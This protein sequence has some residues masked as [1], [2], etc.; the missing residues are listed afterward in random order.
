[1]EW[2]DA[3]PPFPDQAA[4]YDHIRKAPVRK[5]EVEKQNGN[6]DEAFKTAARV[7]EAEYEWPFQSHASMGPACAL[8][9]IKDGQVTCW[10]GSQKPHFTARRRGRRFS[11]C[12]PKGAWD[13][14]RG[15][16]LLRPQ[17][18]RR[19]GDGRRGARQGRRPAGARAIH[20]RAGHRLGPQGPGLDP[21]RARGDRCVRQGDRLRVHQQGLLARRRHSNESQPA[22]TLAGQLTDVPLESGRCF[23]VPA[24]SYAFANKRTWETIAPLLDRARRCAPRICAIRSDRRSISPANPSSTKWRPRRRRSDRVPPAPHQGAAR[25]RR[26]QGGGREVRLAVAALAAP[27]PDRQHRL[28]PRQHIRTWHPGRD[29]RRSRHRPLDRENLGAQ[30]HGRARLRTDHQ[31]RRASR[32]SRA[33]SSR[34]SAARCGKR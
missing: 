8:V 11:T 5:R 25:H 1:M 7:I 14:G 26:D 30:V 33:T 34:A 31:S 13:L 12:R 17:R 2:S 4:I 15:P 22:D 27:R 16:R 3:K 32:P 19:C 6:V 29:R 23:G 28:R 18:R 21:P 24:E 9:E 10:T 20:A